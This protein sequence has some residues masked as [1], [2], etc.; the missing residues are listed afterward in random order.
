MSDESAYRTLVVDDDVEIHNGIKFGLSEEY[1]IA[2][3]YSGEEAVLLARKALFPVVILDLLMGGISGIETMEL[4]RATWPYYKFIVLTGHSSEASAIA[5]LN[6]GAFRYLLKPFS[7][8]ALRDTVALAYQSYEREVSVDVGHPSC[9][10]DLV[11]LGF[12]PREA[13]VAAGILQNKINAAIARELN[14]SVRTVEKHCER[15]SVKTG[16]SSR[17]E[18]QYELKQKH[19]SILEGRL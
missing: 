9:A 8:T 17:A 3:A 12:S 11:K 14:I 7:F 10:V 6:K 4:L 13:D 16:I 15:I 2:S 18:L 5:A 19:R 1:P